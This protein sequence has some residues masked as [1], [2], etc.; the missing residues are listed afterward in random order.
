MNKTNLTSSFVEYKKYSS[1]SLS[2][3]RFLGEKSIFFKKP[4]SFNMKGCN[5]SYHTLIYWFTVNT[6][7]RAKKSLCLSVNEAVIQPKKIENRFLIKSYS[8]KH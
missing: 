6:I 7:K 4:K 1:F 5:M 8:R 3:N 2:E